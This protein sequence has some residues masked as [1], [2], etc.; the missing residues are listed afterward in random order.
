MKFPK[1]SVCPTVFQS[2]IRKPFLIETPGLPVPV[3]ADWVSVLNVVI[4][5]YKSANKDAQHFVLEPFLC[6]SYRNWRREG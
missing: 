5:L 3:M 6:S 1:K 4:A 2:P